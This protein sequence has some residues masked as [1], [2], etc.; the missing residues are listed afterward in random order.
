MA[1]DYLGILAQ[2]E[3]RGSTGT[4]DSRWMEWTSEKRWEPHAACH[5]IGRLS[6]TVDGEEVAV[7]S[8]ELSDAY[9]N[10]FAIGK[11]HADAYGCLPAFV[12]KLNRLAVD[13]LPASFDELFWWPERHRSHGT[14]F[15]EEAGLENLVRELYGKWEYA[16]GSILDWTEEEGRP[17]AAL[18][19]KSVRDDSNGTVKFGLYP[20][21][22]D[23]GRWKLVGT[24]FGASC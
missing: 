9:R 23:D 5:K 16:E 22:F 20:V 3:P 17:S 24:D 18:R 2:L 7:V 1:K 15:F 19:V 10:A 12:R 11:K 14:K 8:K 21:V 13:E 4:G 6:V